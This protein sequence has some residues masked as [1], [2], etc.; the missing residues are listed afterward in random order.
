[1]AIDKLFIKKFFL[2]IQMPFW[3]FRA[4]FFWTLDSTHYYTS[5]ALSWYTKTGGVGQLIRG[6]LSQFNKRLAVPHNKFRPNYD[7]SNPYHL[8]EEVFNWLDNEAIGQLD[9]TTIP[10]NSKTR[11]VFEIALN[12]PSALHDV[13]ND[14]L[15][16]SWKYDNTEW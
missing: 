3:H 1:M 6:R 15:L 5:P 12:Y 7:P 16:F 8:P 4:I 10:A 14:L 13:H 11:H 2:R 9:F